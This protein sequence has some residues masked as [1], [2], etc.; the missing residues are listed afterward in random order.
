MTVREVGRQQEEKEGWKMESGRERDETEEAKVGQ[1]YSLLAVARDVLR[2]TVATVQNHDQGFAVV[3]FLKRRDATHQ[4]VE[5][6]AQGPDI[7]SRKDRSGTRKQAE[8]ARC[9]S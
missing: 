1:R 2:D 7:W 3:G 8:A 6:H 9:Y 5:N 4:H